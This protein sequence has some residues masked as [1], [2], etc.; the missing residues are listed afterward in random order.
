MIVA[1]FLCAGIVELAGLPDNNGARP[2]DHDRLDVGSFGMASSFDLLVASQGRRRSAQIV[3]PYRDRAKRFKRVSESACEIAAF[4][5]FVCRRI[6]YIAQ[7]RQM[8]MQLR[9][10]FDQGPAGSGNQFRPACRNVIRAT[11]AA[12]RALARWRRLDS[13]RARGCVAGGLCQL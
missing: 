9:I 10:R 1:G 8:R 2:D 7:T 6:L 5:S 4:P 3:V 11:I 12:E 13:A